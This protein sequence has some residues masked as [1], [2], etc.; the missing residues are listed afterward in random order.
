M[1]GSVHISDCLY[2]LTKLYKCEVNLKIEDGC[3]ALSIHRD[4][5]LNESMT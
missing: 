1:K 4:I 3:S 2:L 5:E